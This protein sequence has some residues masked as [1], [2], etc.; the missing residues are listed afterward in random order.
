MTRKTPR[1]IVSFLFFVCSAAFVYLA[2]GA[3]RTVKIYRYIKARQA[4]WSGTLHRADPWLGVTAI[5]NSVGAHVFPIGPAV[6]ARYDAEGFRVPLDE[7]SPHREPPLLLALGCSGDYGFGCLAEE[8][9]PYKLARLLG[10]HEINAAVPSYGL[11]QILLRGEALIPKYRPAYVTVPYFSILSAHASIPYA[12]THFGLV[13]RPYFYESE[14]HQVRIHPPAFAT[15]AFDVPASDYRDTP[16]G[17]R[18]FM[19]FLMHVSLPV[20]SYDDRQAPFFRTKV[21]LGLLPRP[22]TDIPQIEEYVYGTLADLCRSNGCRLV[23]IITG[24]DQ[25]PVVVPTMLRRPGV[26]IANAHE[27]LLAR[28]TEQSEV[29]FDRQYTHFRGNPPRPVDGHLNSYANTLVAEAAAEAIRA[30]P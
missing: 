15:R 9:Y 6:P 4:G 26:V 19:S 5:P 28:L 21:A 16:G 25:Q 29:G 10:A 17:A 7:T 2:F 8:T 11:A 27:A 1:W 18:D 12:L 3:L 20:L 23:V 13:P 22:A 24:K 30:N 14:G